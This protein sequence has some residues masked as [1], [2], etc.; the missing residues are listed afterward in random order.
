VAVSRADEYFAVFEAAASA[1]DA[2]ISI[3]REL[4]VWR[5]SDGLACRVRLGIDTGRPKLA[6]SGDVGMP[7]NITARIGGAAH[8]GQ[9]LLSEDAARELDGAL[10]AGIDF[11]SSAGRCTT[12]CSPRIC[13]APIEPSPTDPEP[14]APPRRDLSW[15]AQRPGAPPHQPLKRTTCIW[16]E[17]SEVDLPPAGR[18]PNAPSGSLGLHEPSRE[19]GVVRKT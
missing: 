11:E 19:L 1:L 2:G 15:L 16:T 10:P 8:G 14:E 7:V 4:G 18:R 5:W 12:R 9:I 3:Q 17:A 6:S 13:L